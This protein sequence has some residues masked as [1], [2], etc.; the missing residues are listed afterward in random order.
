MN[1]HTHASTHRPTHAHA[2]TH[3]HTHTNPS[4]T[5]AMR[6]KER[7]LK[8]GFQG[9]F[10]R[11]D[12]GDLF[13]SISTWG[14]LVGC[15]FLSNKK[16]VCN[17]YTESISGQISGQ[18]QIQVHNGHPSI[19]W[20]HCTPGTWTRISTAPWAFQSDALP[21]KLHHKYF[22]IFF[23]YF[24]ICRLDY[25][26]VFFYTGWTILLFSLPFIHFLHTWCIYL[27]PCIMRYK[28]IGMSAT[29]NKGHD[30]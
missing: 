24:F 29:P 14:N 3:T 21:T 18:A 7:F 13:Q 27:V 22:F 15:F 17:D 4:H 25:L 11:A 28:S 9:R 5:R 20:L 12:R 8:R 26:F 19:W 6:L 16:H 10:K 30:A 1:T 23:I 2:H